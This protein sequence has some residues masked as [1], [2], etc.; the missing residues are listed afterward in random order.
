MDCQHIQEQLPAYLDGAVPAGEEPLIAA[1]LAS[2]ARCA[3]VRDDLVRAGRLVG[4]L[5]E[6]EA[7]PWLKT[8]VMARVREERARRTGAFWR[9]LSR[10]GLKLPAAAVASLLVAGIAVYVYRAVEPDV[11][12]AAKEQ[13]EPHAKLEAPAPEA[14]APTLTEAPTASPSPA[15]AAPAPA[16]PPAERPADRAEAR[17]APVPKAETPAAG[18]PVGPE[19]APAAARRA[20]GAADRIEKG[21]LPAPAPP[22]LPPG[23]PAAP[24]EAYRKDPAIREMEEA[25]GRLMGSGAVQQDERAGLDAAPGKALA[26]RP[27]PGT[28]EVL[29]YGLS[30]Q[31]RDLARAAAEVQSILAAHGAR[32]ILPIV[33]E[34][35]A[36]VAAEIHPAEIP[37]VDRKLRAL[38][39]LRETGGPPPAS[40]G[41]LRITIQIHAEP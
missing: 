29:P 12:Q 36:T 7:P 11:R 14:K 4:S 39:P 19:Q 8:R 2:C 31:A 34:R 40:D 30:L 33:A 27:A 15:P 1:H 22:A 21:L 9:R 6:V 35:S 18:P 38:G 24:A 41:P 10:F 37:D 5:D 16:V 17:R 32:S 28:A 3:A 20:E 13:A 25:A 26:R 23:P